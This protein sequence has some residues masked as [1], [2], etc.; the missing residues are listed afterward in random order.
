VVADGNSDGS[1]K[2]AEEFDLWVLKRPVSG[3]PAQARN[4]G[5]H[6]SKG[7]LLLFIDADVTV[8]DDTIE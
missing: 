2:L 5:A 7:D 6:Q 3:G 1:W 8:P 4:M